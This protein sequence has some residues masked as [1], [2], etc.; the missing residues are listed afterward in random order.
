M[1]LHS[2]NHLTRL[3]RENIIS[4]L[5]I[6]FGNSHNLH[7]HVLAGN[8]HLPSSREYSSSSSSSSSIKGYSSSSSSREYSSSSSGGEY[9]TDPVTRQITRAGNLLWNQKEIDGPP[10]RP[11]TQ[12]TLESFLL[13]NESWCFQP[14]AVPVSNI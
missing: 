5:T 9:S 7:L 14:H 2:A 8:S 4:T 11:G 3:Q 13:A 10:A 6:Y 1:I 12:T